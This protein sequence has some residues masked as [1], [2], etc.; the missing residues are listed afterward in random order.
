MPRKAPLRPLRR[1]YSRDLKKRII[2]QTQI[3][4]KSSTQIAIDLDMDLR[5]V[6]R[7][8]QTWNEIG[9]VCR[10]RKYKGRSPVMSS[11]EIDFML[12]LLE[13]TPDLYLDEIQEQLADV[14]ELEVSLATISRTLKRLGLNSKKLSK[15]AA[16][17]CEEARQ[18]FRME[19]G[20]ESPERIVTADESAVNILTTY[21]TNGWSYKGIWAR[22]T[23]QFRRGTRL[24]DIMVMNS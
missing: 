15:A 17:R 12:S 13:H 7:V 21:R 5:V 16:E 9:N 20:A 14:H 22:K 1:H 19:I 23:C 2:Y 3:L 24:A 6:Q 8:K 18:Q 4:G 11:T 10:D